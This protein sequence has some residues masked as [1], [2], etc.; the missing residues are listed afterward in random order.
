ME[1]KSNT[2]KAVYIDTDS[3]LT[4]LNDES[5]QALVCQICL[6]IVY[7]PVECELCETL[8]CSAEVDQLKGVCPLCK[9]DKWKT[10]EYIHRS[11]KAKLLGL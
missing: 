8:F 1:R 2:E 10:T 3:L 9:G 5:V 7:H 6:G 11:Y 4:S